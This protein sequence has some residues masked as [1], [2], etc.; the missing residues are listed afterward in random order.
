MA[1]SQGYRPMLEKEWKPDYKVPYTD[2]VVVDYDTHPRYAR[3]T[4]LTKSG[5]P[6]VVTGDRW[7]NRPTERNPS[8]DEI[9]AEAYSKKAS[10]AK[11]I[12]T[13]PDPE[14]KLFLDHFSDLLINDDGKPNIERLLDELYDYWRRSNRL[15][16]ITREFNLSD[17]RIYTASV[18]EDELAKYCNEAVQEVTVR[19]LNTLTN[20]ELG[21]LKYR[22]EIAVKSFGSQDH[23]ERWRKEQS[24]E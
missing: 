22:V 12:S 4:V 20:S 11:G 7:R 18:L 14:F 23:L 19:V 13:S 9:H 6:I 2:L 1:A 15:N 10:E 5:T 3:G 21:D 8:V 16:V 24:G 17:D